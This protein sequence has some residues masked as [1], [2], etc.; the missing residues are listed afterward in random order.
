M[1]KE[2]ERRNIPQQPLVCISKKVVFFFPDCRCWIGWVAL[3]A[4]ATPLRRASSLDEL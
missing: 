4:L 2:P 1:G 3:A